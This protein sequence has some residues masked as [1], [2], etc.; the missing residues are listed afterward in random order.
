MKEKI[1]VWIVDNSIWIKEDLKLY[2]ERDYLDIIFDSP[3]FAEL[4]ES[5]NEG[6]E[7]E[8]G[9]IN[10]LTDEKGSLICS[11]IRKTFQ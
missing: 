4:C 5:I 7:E 1:C 8:K 2:G 9:Y 3:R 10:G 11:L 6:T